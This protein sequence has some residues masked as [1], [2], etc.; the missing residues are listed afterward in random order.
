M[1]LVHLWTALFEI[2]L[3]SVLLCLIWVAVDYAPE[4]WV[5]VAALLF[6]YSSKGV[7]AQSQVSAY[8]ATYVIGLVRKVMLMLFRIRMAYASQ[9]LLAWGE[10]IDESPV[11]E[12]LLEC[13]RVLAFFIMSVFFLLMFFAVGAVLFIAPIVY[14]SVAVRQSFDYG[15][16]CLLYLLA[17]F[18]TLYFW[19]FYSQSLR[20]AK[21]L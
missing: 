9:D 13:V 12:I 20:Q 16:F 19:R 11:L 17:I 21:R 7:L 1:T 15:I 3:L 8:L 18:V 10:Q 6:V 2:V 5:G 4:N 14:F